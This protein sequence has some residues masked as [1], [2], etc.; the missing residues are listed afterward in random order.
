MA[1]QNSLFNKYS[2]YVAGGKTETENNFIEWWERSEFP[3]SSTDIKYVVE[4]FF[5]GRLDL[6][7]NMF[8]KEP[9]WGWI[10]AQ[11]NFILDPFSEVKAGRILF[12]PT[13]ERLAL[14]ISTKQGGVDSKK[15]SVDTI[16]PIII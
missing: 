15:Q 9:R 12:I 2:R 13:P 5:E 6:I 4:N 14:L 8:Y 11:Y 1:E 10:I 7:S 3:R 16:S